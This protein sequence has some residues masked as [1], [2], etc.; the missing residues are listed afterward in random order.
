MR[1]RD[2]VSCAASVTTRWLRGACAVRRLALVPVRGRLRGRRRRPS[3]RRYPPRAWR[4]CRIR[5]PASRVPP[6]CRPASAR[7]GSSSPSRSASTASAS[8]PLPRVGLA[9][10][11]LDAR[12]ASHVSRDVAL[13]LAPTLYGAL[14]SA[15]YVVRVRCSCSS[16]GRRAAR[17]VLAWLAGW[18][19]FVPVAVPRARLRAARR[20]RWLAAARARRAGCSSS[21]TSASR[22]ALARGWQLAPGRLRA[23]ARLA[24]DARA[25]SYCVTQ[26][27][28]AFILRGRRAARRSRDGVRPR[29]TSSS[30]RSSSSAPR[31]STWIRPPGSSRFPAWRS[32]SCSRGCRSR[33]WRR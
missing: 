3:A 23:R 27:V 13:V 30:R 11:V 24:R 32:T 21:R 5:A 29:R 6:R 25:S 8:G 18:L 2:C 33:A 4:G 17:L 31:S 28:L 19:V 22:A 16:G 9:P 12:R 20:S 26:R 15:S 10:A 1:A 7:S 14:L